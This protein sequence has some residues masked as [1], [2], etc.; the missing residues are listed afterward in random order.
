M[1]RNHTSLLRWSLIHDCEHINGERWCWGFAVIFQRRASGLAGP[2]WLPVCSLHTPALKNEDNK[3]PHKRVTGRS[4]CAGSLWTSR[5]TRGALWCRVFMPFCATW[6]GGSLT[7][8]YNLA[9]CWAV[10][11]LLHSGHGRAGSFV[12]CSALR[13][14]GHLA[15]LPGIVWGRGGGGVLWSKSKYVWLFCVTS[16]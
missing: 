13:L 1:G 3:L 6:H 16:I 12:V 10:S 4:V 2:V 9:F 8:L 15:V 5:M 11:R 14:S 7:P